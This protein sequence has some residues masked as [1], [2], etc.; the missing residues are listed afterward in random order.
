MVRLVLIDIDGT[1]MNDEKEIPQ[2]NL[3]AIDWCIRQHIPVTLVT[4]RSYH[5]CLQVLN[6][7]TEDVPV[8]FQN[9]ALIYQPISGKVLRQVFLP[10]EIALTVLHLST[11]LRSRIL[12][13]NSLEKEDMWMTQPYKGPYEIYFQRNQERIRFIDD[14]HTLPLHEVTEIVLLDEHH[15]LQNTLRP[16]E[17]KFRGTFSPIKSFELENEIFFEIFGADVSKGRAAD[18]LANYFQIPLEE[19]MF[20]GDSYN[21]IEIMKLVGYPV[22]MGNAVD[23]VKQKARWITKTNN[24]AGVSWAIQQWIQKPSC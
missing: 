10:Q 16:V 13:L 5:T 3:Q 4:G 2:E 23:E 22:A 8:V 21:D 17:A 6:M 7:L 20:I 14:F 1:L 9:G 12:Y 19:T 24:E 11:S 15:N 18:F